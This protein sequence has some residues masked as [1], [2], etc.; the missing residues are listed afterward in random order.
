MSILKSSKYR[1]M[2]PQEKLFGT[3]QS[4]VYKYIYNII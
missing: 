4:N 1:D 3:K 2:A